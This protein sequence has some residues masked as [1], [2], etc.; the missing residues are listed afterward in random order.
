M[1]LLFR[2]GRIIAGKENQLYFE[3]SVI[4]VE[5][6]FNYSHGKIINMLSYYDIKKYQDEKKEIYYLFGPE[7]TESFVKEEIR[8]LLAE[9]GSNIANIEDSNIIMALQGKCINTIFLDVLNHFVIVIG[10]ENLKKLM[11]QIEMDNW[12]RNHLSFKREDKTMFTEETAS[13]VYKKVMSD[14]I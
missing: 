2:E 11:L 7:T 12:K 4:D 13:P 5:R 10:K 9:D 14:I 6:G 8:K 3:P 1:K